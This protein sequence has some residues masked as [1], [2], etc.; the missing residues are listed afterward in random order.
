MKVNVDAG[1]SLVQPR[2]TFDDPIAGPPDKPPSFKNQRTSEVPRL[3][4]PRTRPQRNLQQPR[5]S[6]ALSMAQGRAPAVGLHGYAAG[7]GRSSLLCFTEDLAR[8]RLVRVDTFKASHCNQSLALY[9]SLPDCM[10]PGPTT[11]R[12]VVS[13]RFRAVHTVALVPGFCPAR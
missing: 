3:R 5:P 10:Q 2:A 4:P 11:I 9:V 8:A 6:R 12:S 7:R 1:H 13:L